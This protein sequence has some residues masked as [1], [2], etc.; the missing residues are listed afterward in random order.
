MFPTTVDNENLNQTNIVFDL[1]TDLSTKL[2]FKKRQVSLN[3]TLLLQ[4]LS[5]VQSKFSWKITADCQRD[6]TGYFIGLL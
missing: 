3:V 6:V 2:S 4:K 5:L 1:L